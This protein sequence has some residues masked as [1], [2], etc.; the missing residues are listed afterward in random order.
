LISVIVGAFLAQ[1]IQRPISQLVNA[2][3]Q[4][5]HLD[6]SE[7]IMIKTNLREVVELSQVLENA[8]SRIENTLSSLQKE[9][10]WSDL[11][12]ESIVEGII[13][14]DDDKVEYFSPGAERI[15]GFSENEVLHKQINSI[16]IPTD[17]SSSFLDLLPP[18]GEKLR[19]K[20]ML[21]EEDDRILA[22][23]HAEQP[24]IG[25]GKSQTVLVLRD[26]NEEEAFSH[27]LGSFLGNIT[28]EFRTPLTALTAS[29][30]ILMEEAEVL[31]PSE[32]F[33]LLSSIHLSILNLAN[34]IDNLLEGSSIETGRFHVNPHPSDLINIIQI[35]HDT[36][37]PLLVKY[38]QRLSISIPSSLPLV[39]VDGRRINQ[40]LLNLISNASKYGPSDEEI[41]IQAKRI[42]NFIEVTIGDRGSGVPV[43]YR[44]KIF[45]GFLPNT[46]E[47][48]RMNKGSGLG[49]SVAQSIVKAHGGQIGVRDRK[50]GGSE[51]WF[52]IPITGET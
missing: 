16:L 45:S 51:F 27:L 17:Q 18:P 43:A 44:N 10:Q 36:I 46:Y 26:V 5:E 38:G 49:L 37:N 39:M 40:V 20:F 3:N 22:I 21:K 6:L 4:Y 25:T 8:R 47:K 52:T 24:I 12:L 11:L 42:E 23:T 33:E 32:M 48:G 28:H 30:E 1:L 34:L 31:E 15:I 29:I 14:L 2:T 35:A 9:K 19:C 41:T 7:P 50:G 13:I